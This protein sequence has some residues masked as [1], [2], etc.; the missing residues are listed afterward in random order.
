[1]TIFLLLPVYLFPSGNPQL[2]DVPILATMIYVFVT[3]DEREIYLIS[4]TSLTFFFFTAWGIVINMTQFMQTYHPFYVMA[5]LQIVYIF[6]LFPTFAILFYRMLEHQKAIPYVYAG[7]VFTS[8]LPLLLHGKPESQ[9]IIRESLS[10]NNPNQLALF[11]L[12]FVSITFILNNHF[13]KHPLSTG[14]RASLA[15]VN[16]LV[17]FLGHYFVLVS[18]SRAALVSIIVI[19]VIW[20]W[21]LKRTALPSFLVVTALLLLLVFNAGLTNFTKD[22]L[23]KM[24]AFRRLY[25]I[26]LSQLLLKRT[27]NRF[28]FENV[29]LIFGNGKTKP[30]VGKNEVHNTFADIIY[31]YG[32]IGGCLFSA[33]LFLYFRTVAYTFY[34]LGIL[35]A[36][37]PM[38]ISHNLLRFRVMWIFLALIYSLALIRTNSR[39]ITI[40][41]SRG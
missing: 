22:N 20:C 41:A 34:N 27:E 8:I 1:M 21:S 23:L 39:Q 16:V 11:S 37:V 24:A 18:A 19:D 40:T 15:A 7:I 10:F 6:L 14:K 4:L 28:V 5:S 17:L 35:I 30:V 33:F 25:N 12:S 38:H 3:L 13:G 9:F 31:S 26:E 2:V 32:I 29:S 36:F